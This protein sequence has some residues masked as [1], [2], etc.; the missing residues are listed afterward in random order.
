MPPHEAGELVGAGIDRRVGIMGL[1]QPLHCQHGDDAPIMA[2]MRA[3]ELLAE[4][5]L[6]GSRSFQSIV[7]RIN[8]LLEAPS[9][10][11]N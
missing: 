10:A 11:L 5:D 7:R 2:A 8:H 6:E 3:D 4:R 9:G 1:R